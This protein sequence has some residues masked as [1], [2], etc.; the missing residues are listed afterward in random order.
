LAVSLRAALST[1]DVRIV[2]LDGDPPLW[3]VLVG[4]GLNMDAAKELA[5]RVKQLAGDSLVVRE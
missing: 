1:R 5:V 2:T 3:R 4:S